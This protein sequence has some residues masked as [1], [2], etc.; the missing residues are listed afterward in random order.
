MMC[1]LQDEFLPAMVSAQPNNLWLIWQVLNVFHGK[2]EIDR[3]GLFATSGKTET[4]AN[5]IN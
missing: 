4:R 2:P 3:S 5:W 1:S